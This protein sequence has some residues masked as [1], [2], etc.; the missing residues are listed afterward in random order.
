MTVETSRT[1]FERA[2]EDRRR[3]KT[4]IADVIAVSDGLK[5]ASAPVLRKI[6]ER[7]ASD[8]FRVMVCGEFKRGKSTLINAML[9]QKVLP[10]YARPA[11]AVLTEL[12]WSETSSAVLYPIDGGAP[13]P[14]AVEDLIKHITIPKGV[15]QDAEDTGPWKLAEVSW[16]LELLRNNVV[17]I[18][19]PGLNEHPARQEITL[20]NLSRADAIVFVQDCQHTVSIEEVRFMDLYLDAYDVFFV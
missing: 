12:R 9:G 10:A 17:L 3:L 20:Q 7:V 2:D 15:P 14:V 18:D 11:T 5:A 1:G 13:V 19:S 16:P 8:A 4:I 6:E